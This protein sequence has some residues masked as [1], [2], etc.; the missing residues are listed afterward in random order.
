MRASW[1]PQGGRGYAPAQAS[2]RRSFAPI[3]PR[4]V[5]SANYA[6]RY[7]TCREARAA[8]AAPLYRGQP[9]YSSQLDRDDDGT[10]CEPYRG[11]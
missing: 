11:R 5:A 9:G 1:A 2:S 6:P 4:A 8:G 7:R 3:A 10:A